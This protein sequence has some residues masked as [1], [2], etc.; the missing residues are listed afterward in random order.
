VGVYPYDI[1]LL[2][3]ASV[4]KT[5]LTERLGIA[6]P[7]VQA[8]M[9][10][11]TTAKIAVAVGRAGG[12]GIIG[13]GNAPADWVGEQIA[14]AKSSG[15]GMYG[16]NVPLF[17]PHTAEVIQLAAQENVP[18]VTTGAGNPTRYIETLKR[19]GVYVMPVV[20][21]SAQARRLADAG[22]DAVIAEGTEAGGHVG[23]VTTLALVPRIVDT[24][25]VPVVAA[26]GI[27]DGRG[28]VAALS[29]GASAVQM[30]TRFVCSDECIAHVAYKEALIRAH[31]RSTLVTGQ[32]IDHPVRCLRNP[33]TRA[34]R[35]MEAEGVTREELLTFGTG[36]YRRAIIE[37]DVREGSVMA[38]QGAGL[39][40]ETLP[41]EEIIH[42]TMTE[43][44][45]VLDRLQSMTIEEGVLHD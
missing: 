13:A 22:A 39:V 17:S 34:F 45:R 7:I 5:V 33:L 8:G 16:V 41:A 2:E 38:G 23:D 11:V 10:W 35:R 20:A 27:C 21:S 15:I 36:R 9:A 29:L 30:G 43:A 3:R 40:H 44:M 26:G 6:Y 14:Q 25:D 24:V 12:L 18:V 4:I 31:E 42:R 1:C 37:G 28:L 32:V 19:A